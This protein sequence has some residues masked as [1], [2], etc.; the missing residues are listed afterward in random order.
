MSSGPHVTDCKDEDRRKMN[1]IYWSD[2]CISEGL[3]PPSPHDTPVFTLY[4]TPLVHIL[5]N[6]IRVLLGVCVLNRKYDFSLGLEEV[7]YAYSFKRH[8][9][10]RYYLVVDAKSLQLVTNLLTISKNK[11]QGNVLLFDA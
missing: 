11:T 6:I 7:L 1:L 3:V 2:I 10:E 5:V 4:P 9:L 8:N